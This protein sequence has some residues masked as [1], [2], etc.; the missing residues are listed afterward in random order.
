MLAVVD[1][2]SDLNL[3]A[4]ERIVVVAPHPDDESLG[5]G[6]LIAS[7]RRRDIVVWVIF[8]TDGTGSHRHS[9]TVSGSRLASLRR[10]EALHALA[11]LGVRK[12]HV[13]RLGMKDRFVPRSPPGMAGAVAQARRLLQDLAPTLLV[14][15]STCDAHGDHKASAAIWRQAAAPLSALRQIEYVVWPGRSFPAG[16]RLMLDISPVLQ[17]KRQAVHVH[18]S[19]RGLIITDDP[20]GFVLPSALVK[21]SKAHQETYWEAA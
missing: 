11:V 4:R 10:R 18:R 7:A 6:G 12:Y 15:P 5:C 9:P 8:V 20:L 13:R 21:R 1:D 19:Q 16:R 3:T 2:S 14:R 17:L